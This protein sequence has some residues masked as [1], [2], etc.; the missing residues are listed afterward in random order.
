MN[1]KSFKDHSEP[2][3]KQMKILKLKDLVTFNN[4]IF[5]YDQLS[6]NL[7]NVFTEYFKPTGRQQGG[8]K[9]YF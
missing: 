3:Y 7:P 2:L 8:L 4:C 1:F 5:A 6:Q 9:I